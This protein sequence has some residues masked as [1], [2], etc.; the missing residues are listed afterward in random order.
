MTV[1]RFPGQ[2]PAPGF[3]I[4]CVKCGY[5]AE[6]DCNCDGP[7]DSRDWSDALHFNTADDAKNAA[8]AL[9]SELFPADHG[10]ASAVAQQRAS[11]LLPPDEPLSEAS[12][13]LGLRGD[14]ARTISS[15]A[16][17][18]G[19]AEDGLCKSTGDAS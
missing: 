18:F 1:R 10:D 12:T 2:V 8:T 7:F 5:I 13:V 6:Y 14:S 4:V 15:D 19:A 11:E 17:A 3:L 16:P 9:R